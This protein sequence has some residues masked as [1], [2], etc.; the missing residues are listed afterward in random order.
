MS[1]TARTLVLERGYE[2]ISVEA[3]C[4]AAEISRSTFFR[5]F[6]SKEDAVLTDIE[7]A[8]ETLRSALSARPGDE[9][10]WTAVHRALEPLVEQYDA[11]P[12]PARPLAALTATTPALAAYQHEKHS[13][14]RDALRPEICRRI[15]VDPADHTDPRPTAI[16]AAALACLDAAITAWATTEQTTPIS[17]LLRAAMDSTRL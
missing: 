14:W 2:A 9:P 6:A 4:S 8:A 7:E 11:S 13:A 1:N 3:I 12:E 10:V 16:L 17:A 15:G 5:Y